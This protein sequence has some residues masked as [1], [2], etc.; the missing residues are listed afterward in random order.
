MPSSSAKAPPV[1]TI[2]QCPDMARIPRRECDVVAQIGE[3][4]TVFLILAAAG[5]GRQS[6]NR[7]VDADGAKAV[8]ACEGG[9]WPD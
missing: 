2:W 6:R 4:L 1:A 5:G 3:G 7:A 9:H 8:I